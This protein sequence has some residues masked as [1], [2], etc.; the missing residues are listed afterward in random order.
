[1][2]ALM[3]RVI[4]SLFLALEAFLMCACFVVLLIKLVDK[5]CKSNAK[6]GLYMLIH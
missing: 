6:E 1:M 3:H 4:G 2:C 5:P